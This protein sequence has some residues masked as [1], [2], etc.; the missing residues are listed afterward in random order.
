VWGGDDG[1]G[2]VASGA[3]YNPVTDTWSPM[4]DAP[5]VR[6]GHTAIWTGTEMIV[7]GGELFDPPGAAYNPAHDT[8]RSIATDSAPSG[9]ADHTAVWTGS[10]MIVWGGSDG[11]LTN[12]GGRYAP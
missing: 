12:T 1:S 3:R 11:M 8:W 2:P 5:I 10:E 9:R 6:G 4:Q 7:W